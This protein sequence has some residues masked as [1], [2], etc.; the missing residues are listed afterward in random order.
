MNAKRK[1]SPGGRKNA[2]VIVAPLQQPS[3]FKIEKSETRPG[4]AEGGD[5]FKST[6]PRKAV[7]RVFQ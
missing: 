7:D 4:R 1:I 5:G 2:S 3:P 6:H